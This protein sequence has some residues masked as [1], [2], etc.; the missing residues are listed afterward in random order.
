[1]PL[2]E[3]NPLVPGPLASCGLLLWVG[4]LSVC[5]VSAPLFHARYS[6]TSIGSF[7]SL[8]Q[9]FEM[10]DNVRTTGSVGAREAIRP[11]R[12]LLSC[13]AL[14]E[15][16]SVVCV[17]ISPSAPFRFRFFFCAATLTASDTRRHSM[18]P[19]L[20]LVQHPALCPLSVVGY[21]W[22]R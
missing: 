12:Y 8:A 9:S 6:A 1:M 20:G 11:Q 7:G 14:P 15:E 18:R 16:T 3:K 22:S 13:P 4:D 2:A 21:G 17:L 19:R 5:T 10:F